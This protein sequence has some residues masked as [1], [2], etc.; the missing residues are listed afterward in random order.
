[1]CVECEGT[2]AVRKKSLWKESIEKGM[3]VS[4]MPFLEWNIFLG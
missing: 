1:M 2:M 3:S 4:Y